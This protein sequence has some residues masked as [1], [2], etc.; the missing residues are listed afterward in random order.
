MIF[1]FSATMKEE[2]WDV[3]CQ[4][5]QTPLTHHLN[6]KSSKLSIDLHEILSVKNA[7]KPIRFQLLVHTHMH[8]VS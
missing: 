5:N 4:S 3:E 7:C 6:G 2:D 1:V 8:V